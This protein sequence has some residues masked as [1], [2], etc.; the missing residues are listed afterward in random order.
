MD[1]VDEVDR[2]LGWIA[3]QGDVISTGVRDLDPHSLPALGGA[4]HH[5][6]NAIGEIF[7]QIG[8]QKLKDRTTPP[9]LIATQG[10]L[11]SFDSDMHE[12]LLQAYSISQLLNVAAHQSDGMKE[13]RAACRLLPGLLWQVQEY[14]A[15][16]FDSLPKSARD[17]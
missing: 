11:P 6:A 5:A 4:I 8:E 10:S 14:I 7:D 9:A 3:A 1:Q 2:L 16:N 15:A 13:A 17:E 12:T